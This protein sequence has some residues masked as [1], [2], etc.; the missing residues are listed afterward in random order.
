MSRLKLKRPL[1][2]F[3]IESTGIN[4]RT[5]RIIDLCIIKLSPDGT[6][7]EYNFRVNPEMPIPPEST[8]KQ[9]IYVV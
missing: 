3:D 7:K 2:V 1:A 4:R 6:R 8:D 5:D 9:W